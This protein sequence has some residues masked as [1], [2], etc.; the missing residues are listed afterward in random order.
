[1]GTA[2]LIPYQEKALLE[3]LPRP[4]I[5]LETAENATA[6]FNFTFPHS[7][8]LLIG[9][10]EYGLTAKTIKQADA[11]IQIPLFGSKNSLNVSCAFAIIAAQIRK[12][13][14]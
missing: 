5:A 14:A 11:I 7:F 4:L 12:D 6:Y 9:N 8:S 2:K 1:M 3:D 13:L 10:E